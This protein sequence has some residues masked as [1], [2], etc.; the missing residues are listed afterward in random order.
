M[1]LVYVLIVSSISTGLLFIFSFKLEKASPPTSICVLFFR[2]ERNRCEFVKHSFQLA[3]IGQ[4]KFENCFQIT[5][6]LLIRLDFFKRIFG[7]SIHNKHNRSYILCIIKHGFSNGTVCRLS[8]Q[9][10]SSDLI[11]FFRCLWYDLYPST[12]APL[13]FSFMWFFCGIS[14]NKSRSWI[15]RSLKFKWFWSI[16]SVSMRYDAMHITEC[17]EL[18]E[19]TMST[20][21]I[22][23]TC[24][25][26]AH[27]EKRFNQG[28]TTS[29]R[30]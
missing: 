7:Y 10:P 29:S 9:V 15:N 4:T 23:F 2:S 24:S 28:L 5:A 16:Q 22:R 27:M 11:H 12:Q 3:S 14:E 6:L 20:N 17:I 19:H 1:F 25:L 8:F 26:V 13:R 21:W 18:P 30:H